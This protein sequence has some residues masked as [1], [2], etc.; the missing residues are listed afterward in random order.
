M[1]L[2]M[3]ER[4]AVVRVAAERYRKVG[5]KQK[6]QILDELVEVTGHNRWYAV[7]LLR[8]HGKTIRGPGRVRLVGDLALK[9]KR[10]RRRIYDAVLPPLRQIWA[11]LDFICGKRLAAMLPEVIPVLERYHEIELEAMTRDR[12][13]AISP[14]TIDRLLAPERRKFELHGLRDQAW[15]A[16]Q[17]PNPHSYLYRVGS[18]A[19]GV[20]RDRSGGP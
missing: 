16:A 5:K 18:D 19:P 1:R 4:R 2:T 11:I 9:G 3:S 10:G 7:W 8:R 20:R 17:A 14:A 15:D 13:L 12:L 6:G